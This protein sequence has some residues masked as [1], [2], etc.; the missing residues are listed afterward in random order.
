MTD[1]KS[2]MEIKDFWERAAEAPVDTQGLRPTARDPYLQL[3]VEEVIEGYLWPNARLIDIGCGDGS[4]TIR[5]A[6]KVASATGLDYIQGFVDAAKENAAKNNLNNLGFSQGDVT[7][8]AQIYTKEQ[9]FDI[10][11]SI[12]CLIN[13]PEWSLQKRGL[14]EIAKCIRP[15]GLYLCSEGWREGWDGLNELRTRCDLPSIDVVAYNKLMSRVEFE[16]EASQY[17]DIVDYRGLGF[18]LFMSRVIQP[19]LRRPLP[20]E[21]THE[22]NRIGHELQKMLRL[23]GRFDDCDY[24]GVYV[25]RRHKTL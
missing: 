9:P 25:L 21:H 6:Q 5:F 22:L 1:K 17:F 23:S 11:I 15:G 12:R 8:L 20:P 16:S 13:L 24:A 10:A 7:N 14:A 19:Y 4:S 18:Y 3:A 2:L